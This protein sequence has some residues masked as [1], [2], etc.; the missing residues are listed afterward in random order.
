KVVPHH[1]PPLQRTLYVSTGTTGVGT[2]LIVP[3]RARA[4]CGKNAATAAFGVVRNTKGGRYFCALL[5][6]LRNHPGELGLL[7]SAWRAFR[8]V[9]RLLRPLSRHRGRQTAS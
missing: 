6:R 4:R 2:C 1:R 9:A 5:R 7:L 3:R 8:C